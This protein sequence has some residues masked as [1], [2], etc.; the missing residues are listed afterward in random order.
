M[1]LLTSIISNPK[2]I[3]LGYG[4]MLIGLIVAILF[5]PVKLG[6]IRGVKQ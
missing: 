2:L 6:L 5:I 3:V 1:Q 4:A